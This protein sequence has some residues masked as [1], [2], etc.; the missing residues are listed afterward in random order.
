MAGYELYK[1]LFLWPIKIGPTAVTMNTYQVCEVIR[2]Y[3]WPVE[4]GP[5]GSG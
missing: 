3:T 1:C 2:T 5:T 4:T